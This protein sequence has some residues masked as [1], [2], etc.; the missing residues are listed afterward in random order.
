MN[1]KTNGFVVASILSLVLSSGLMACGGN[2]S[3]SSTSHPAPEVTAGD[4][5]DT[6]SGDWNI[7]ENLAES[8]YDARA[9]WSTPSQLQIVYHYYDI[10][11]LTD[12][13]GF[14][15]TVTFTYTLSGE[16]ESDNPQFYAT[17]DCIDTVCTQ[18]TM[19]IGYLGESDSK[20]N[21]T[22]LVSFFLKPF[23]GVTKLTTATPTTTAPEYNIVQ[24]LN[25]LYV[26]GGVAE[27]FQI[28]NGLANP[29]RIILNLGARHIGP[30]LDPL[31]PNYWMD[32]STTKNDA[33]TPVQITYTQFPDLN[34]TYNANKTL[35]TGSSI[36][37]DFL[38]AGAL[39]SVKS[40]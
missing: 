38:N 26:A 25:T 29:Y 10:D 19:F 36:E 7:A 33:S 31:Y 4:T 22:A 39:S 30:I 40:N 23:R 9:L 13:N 5:A 34:L 16:V 6:N 11:H 14:L 21:G 2:N 35:V 32:F 18:G 24:A 28:E 12:P 27:G 8:L 37:F 3:T 1:V 15:K 17:V 20:L